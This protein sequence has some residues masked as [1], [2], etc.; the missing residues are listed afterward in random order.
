MLSAPLLL[1]NLGSVDGAADASPF[2]NKVHSKTLSVYVAAAWLTPTAQSLKKNKLILENALVSSSHTPVC[3]S[4]AYTMHKLMYAHHAYFTPPSSVNHTQT[5]KIQLKS[6][7]LLA[8]HK[9]FLL[10]KHT[11]VAR[12][13]Q[14]HPFLS[15]LQDHY[16]KLSLNSTRI[17]KNSRVVLV[18]SVK[19]F[20]P[21]V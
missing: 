5:D 7:R 1:L 9:Q 14:S 11:H 20:P 18:T 2:S 21:M 6:H 12:M 4:W 17:K 3:S 15:A 8:K 10:P 13:F 16:Y 19:T